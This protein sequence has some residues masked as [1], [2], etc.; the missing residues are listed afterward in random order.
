MF[1]QKNKVR[2][3]H[4]KVLIIRRARPNLQVFVEE[5]EEEVG[6]IYLGFLIMSYI[7][8]FLALGI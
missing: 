5:E 7:Q 3:F 1:K 6:S 4:R 2:G 8:G